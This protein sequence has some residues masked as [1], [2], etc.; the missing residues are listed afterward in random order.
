MKV[1]MGMIKQK[2]R[3]TYVNYSIKKKFTVIEQEEKNKILW[4]LELQ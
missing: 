3:R 4:V 1:T 2:R